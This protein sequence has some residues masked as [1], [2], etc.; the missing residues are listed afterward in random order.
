VEITE[1][2]GGVP[3]RRALLGCKRGWFAGLIGSSC[4]FAWGGEFS[5]VGAVSHEVRVQ[6][7]F[8]KKFARPA[9]ALF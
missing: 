8:E 1:L 5:R 4:G 7:T 3:F 2:G 6:W 9:G